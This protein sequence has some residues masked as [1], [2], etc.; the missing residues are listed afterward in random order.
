MGID[1]TYEQ[2]YKALF[3]EG[4][5]EYVPDGTIIS[6][7][8]VDLRDGQIADCFLLYLFSKDGTKY[9]GPTARIIVNSERRE[10]IEYKSVDDMPFSV[11]DGNAYYSVEA[12]G[13][14]LE[15]LQKTEIDYQNLY[16][17]VRKI[18]F[19][20]FV[21]QE[22]KET[23]IQYIKILKQV[24]PVHLLPYMFE[25]GHAFFMWAKKMIN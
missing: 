21:L 22:D 15:Y 6:H 10:L 3:A 7:P 19:S 14:Q 17:K 25:L 13:Q 11:C 20:D 4:V 8:V 5:E 2:I 18:A 23:I 1:I 9:T 12:T 16:L 24:E